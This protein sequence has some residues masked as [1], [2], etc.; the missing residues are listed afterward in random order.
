[1]GFQNPAHSAQA[2]HKT[3]SQYARAVK[4]D[5]ESC[6]SIPMQRKAMCY[7]GMGQNQWTRIDSQLTGI[8][9]LTHSWLFSHWLWTSKW[10]S[11]SSV[12]HYESQTPTASL[13]AT[14]LFTAP[15]RYRSALLD[16]LT[17]RVIGTSKKNK[18]NLWHRVEV[19][20]GSLAQSKCKSPEG[21]E[22]RVKMLLYSYCCRYDHLMSGYLK[23][24]NLSPCLQKSFPPSAL[25]TAMVAVRTTTF[26]IVHPPLPSM[27]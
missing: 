8:Y 22:E 24:A 15:C 10:P 7:M 21:M 9:C 5:T 13:L 23:S 11:K 25:S 20:A 4:K 27:G 12:G 26:L 17:C 18:R 6:R 2:W 16:P 1:M 3:L 19:S 14:V